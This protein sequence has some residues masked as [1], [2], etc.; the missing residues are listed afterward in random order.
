MAAPAHEKTWQFNVNIPC[1]TSAT[2]ITVARTVMFAIKNALIGFASSPWTVWGSC[3]GQGGAGS[4]GN[5]DSSDR[6]HAADSTHMVWAA[7]ASNHSWIVL[8]QT[9]LAAKA[10][11]CIDLST[12]TSTSCTVVLSPSAGFG[13]ANGGGDG[14]A[15]ARPTAS[16]QVVILNNSTWGPSAGTSY[17]KVHVLLSTDGK[18]T[19]V[20]N[21][22]GGGL[23]S[24][25]GVWIIDAPK[26]PIAAWTNPSF[27]GIKGGA[28]GAGVYSTWSLTAVCGGLVG[29][30]AE[31]FYVTTECYRGASLVQKEF[32]DDDSAEWPVFGT[33]LFSATAGRVGRKSQI[34]DLYF[35]SSR[36]DPGDCYPNDSHR[37]W[38]QFDQL[39]FPWNGSVPLIG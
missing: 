5:G 30:N 26:N 10:A 34:Y 23:N 20:I 24:V 14:T 16:D 37:H 36:R 32:P 8:T 17:H 25:Y 6:W 4:F 15:T 39:I 2:G 7:A 22:S 33:G 27:A 9:G 18:C 31:T 11:I 29:G 13:A 35:G 12:A 19:R 38:V 3:D 21:C 1:G 28:S